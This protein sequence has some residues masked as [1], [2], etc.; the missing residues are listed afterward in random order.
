MMHRKT[1]REQSK[2]VITTP[3]IWL[4]TIIIA[5]AVIIIAIAQSQ[6]KRH[7]AL[8]SISDKYHMAVC[9]L[10]LQLIIAIEDTHALTRDQNKNIKAPSS[11]QQTRKDLAS[12]QLIIQSIVQQISAI[13]DL[14]APSSLDSEHTQLNNA[15]ANVQAKLKSFKNGQFTDTLYIGT[16]LTSLRSSA[17]KLYDSHQLVYLVL[18]DKITTLQ[19]KTK[20][21]VLLI[22]LILVII[23]V[24][25]VTFLYKKL[26]KA[27]EHLDK[28]KNDL[29]KERDFST[30]FLDTAPLIILLLDSN[31]NIVYVNPY[32]EKL[33]GYCLAEIKGKSWITTFLPERDQQKIQLLLEKTIQDIPVDCNI[34]PILLKNGEERFIEW[35]A[36]TAG[37]EDNRIEGVLS[38][39]LDVSKRL[40]DE[41]Q[42]I[43]QARIIDQVHDSVISTDLD[44]IIL[45]WNKG[46]EKQSGYSRNEMI[47]KHIS[48]LYPEEAAHRAISVRNALGS[49]GVPWERMS[50]MGWGEHRPV[51]AN[52]VGKGTAANRRVE[53]FLVNS[54]SAD[55]TTADAPVE[56]D[57]YEAPASTGIDPTK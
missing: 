15:H 44:G 7:D 57:T 35:Y 39:G 56:I 52:N 13:H 54:T 10:S 42:I 17:Q 31:G 51:M 37:H 46:A 26:S 48:L 2:N 11:R 4:L 22:M 47:G 38:I 36:R 27:V 24:I 53:I 55:F 3:V 43:E 32:F 19:H 16:T 6:H 40:K 1:P 41:Q 50:A 20:R 5:V 18:Q 28:I 12:S 45:N 25:S 49:A 23:A 33:T 21:I 30:S 14:Y 29:M 9:D 8:D 34:N